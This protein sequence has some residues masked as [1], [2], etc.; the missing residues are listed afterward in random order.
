M[1]QIFMICT[2]FGY[3]AAPSSATLRFFICVNHKNLRHLRDI[4][5][6]NYAE[7]SIAV[8]LSATEV[9]LLLNRAQRA[10][11]HQK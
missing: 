10:H 1:T 2:D 3:L 8:I 6:Q 9:V 4:F 7:R 11:E 5:T